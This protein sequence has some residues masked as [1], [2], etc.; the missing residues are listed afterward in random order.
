MSGNDPNATNRL[1]WN[2][3]SGEYQDRHGDTLA[4]SPTAWGTWRTPETDLK[5]L[6]ETKDRDVLEFGCG[7]AQWSSALAQEGARV[8]GLDL[9]EA[10]LAQARRLSTETGIKVALVQASAEQTP[11]ANASFDVVFCDHGAMSFARPEHTVAEASRLL[12]PGGLLAFCMSTP[13]RDIC[14]DE[15]SE[16]VEPRLGAAYFDL[17]RIDEEGSV[18]YQ[19]P[20]G[21]WIRLFRRHSLSVDDLIEIRP[22]ENAKT[23]YEDYV[24][25][26]WARR[27]PSDHIWKLSK[28]TG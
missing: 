22:P 27:W 19:M 5:V 14:W 2:R 18:Q 11:F 24:S 3:E 1:W 23:T 25:L 17:A 13:L 7:A 26:D 15:A 9:S 4:R 12:R 20:Y 10:Q 6:G 28:E 8:V 16:S 21:E